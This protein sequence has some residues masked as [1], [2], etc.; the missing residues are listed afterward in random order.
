MP[1][2]RHRAG[3][4]VL[5]ARFVVRSLVRLTMRVYFRWRVVNVPKIEGGFVLVANH[6]SFL[7]PIV[8]GAA[9]PRDVGFLI[10]S[11][12]YRTPGLG[13]IIRLFDRKAVS[14]AA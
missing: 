3:A 11:V 12:S 4:L 14:H 1:E 13:W 5:L 7:D 6:A 10:N 9:S 8:I 2:P